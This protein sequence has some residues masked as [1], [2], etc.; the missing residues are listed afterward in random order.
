[1]R[2]ITRLAVLSAMS[3]AT[4]LIPLSTT[5]ADMASFHRES[6]TRR[7]EDM[8][9]E[10]DHSM[11]RMKAETHFPSHSF[12][13]RSEDYSSRSV[14]NKYHPSYD[15]KKYHHHHHYHIDHKRRE[16]SHR[17]VERETYHYV[18]RE[19]TK[20]RNVYVNRDN[21]G[22][23]L[24]AGVLGLAAGAILGNV[25]KQPAQPQIIYQMPPQ[26][27]VVY[28]RVPQNQ[29]VYQVQESVE[30]L[31][32]EQTSTAKWL[33]YC[34]KKYRSFNPQTGTFRGH[35]GLDHVCYAPVN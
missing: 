30:Y 15:S 34:R 6:V 11:K 20:Y 31:P 24:A 5:L 9:K 13:I 14:L 1:M 35:D 8:R 29:V 7:I 18:E 22:N 2:K 19:K 32:L 21:S 3:T 12:R 16:K 27:Q 10:M 17:H 25:L 4:V 23:A 26:N 33:E 28:Q